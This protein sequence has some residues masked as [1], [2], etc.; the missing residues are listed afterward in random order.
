MRLDDSWTCSLLVVFC[1]W[2]LLVRSAVAFSQ[3]WDWGNPLLAGG[4]LLAV[5]W[6]TDCIQRMMG[7]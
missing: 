4:V 7:I 6:A 2:M 3:R 1:A 5:V